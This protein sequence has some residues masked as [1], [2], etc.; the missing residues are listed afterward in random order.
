MDKKPQRPR[1][2]SPRDKEWQRL[3]EVLSAQDL[4]RA[5][6]Q[7]FLTRPDYPWILKML[8][9]QELRSYPCEN[10]PVL[11]ALYGQQ[12]SSPVLTEYLEKRLPG[13]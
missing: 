1:V 3:G 7:V 10:H 2:G 4:Q 6:H 5:V 12:P 8:L 13:W 9:E 11:R